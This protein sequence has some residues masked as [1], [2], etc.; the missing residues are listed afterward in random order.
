[1][2]YVILVLHY[3]KYMFLSW[4]GFDSHILL[5]LVDGYVIKL[6]DVYSLHVYILVRLIE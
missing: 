5:Q 2:C 4:L 3:I 6:L 1:M